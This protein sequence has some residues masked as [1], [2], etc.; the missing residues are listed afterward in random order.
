MD[1][2]NA[3]TEYSPLP[4]TKPTMYFQKA[5]TAALLKRISAANPIL[6]TLNTMLPHSLPIPLPENLS[7]TRLCELGSSDPAIAHPAFVALMAELKEPSRPPL[8]LTLDG[9]AHAMRDSEYKS[10]SF[11]PI[12]AHSLYL[13]SWFMDHL[14]GKSSLPNGGMVLAATSGSNSPTVP[15]LNFR[16]EQLEAQQS[17]AA[18]AL[19]PRADDP[20]LPFLL[21]TGQEPNPIPQPDPFLRHDQRVLD[22]LGPT[23][24]DGKSLAPAAAA[25]RDRIEVLR[26]GGL[27][28]D[29]ARSLM[30]YW[31]RSGM[32]RAKVDETLVGE[33]WIISGG[34]VVGELERGCVRM[35]L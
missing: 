12:H 24:A 33:K 14:S 23:P 26:M 7:L 4:N 20:A 35:R 1:L 6:S 19:V 15:T 21:A 5:Y 13:V 10:A 25:T 9:L 17:L 31:A 28:K 22:V 30:E 8:L 16:L 2:T 34:G 18:G 29:D 32:L 27:P 11:Q 3:H